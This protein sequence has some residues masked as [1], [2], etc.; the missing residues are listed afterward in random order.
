MPAIKKHL[1]RVSPLN[2]DEEDELITVF[3]DLIN[4]ERELEEAKVRLA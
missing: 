1:P 3:K 2:A 4:H